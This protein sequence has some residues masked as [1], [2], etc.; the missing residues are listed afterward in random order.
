MNHVIISGNV[1][2]EPELFS[3][4]GSEFSC[5]KFG[6]ANNDERKKEG[7]SWVDVPNFFDLEYWT[8]KPQ[9]WLSRIHKGDECIA[10]CQMKQQVWEQEGTKRSRIILR[11]LKF[12]HMH[13]KQGKAAGTEPPPTGSFEDDIPF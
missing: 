7:D 13:A 5:I 6:I 11:V 4:E 9:E 12:P 8:K 2:R 1:T 10:E 3:P